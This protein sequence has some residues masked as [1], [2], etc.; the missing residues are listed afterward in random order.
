MLGVVLEKGPHQTD[1]GAEFFAR[2]RPS[3]G[4]LRVAVLFGIAGAASLL[5][6]LLLLLLAGQDRDGVGH[7][8]K[9]KDH[10]RCARLLEPGLFCPC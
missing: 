10:V 5:I 6:L 8:E 7:G 3:F 1:C 4:L 9:C 2:E